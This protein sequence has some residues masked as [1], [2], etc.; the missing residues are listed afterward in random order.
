MDQR[1]CH[2]ARIHL[3]NHAGFHGLSNKRAGDIMQLGETLVA[4]EESFVRCEVHDT[5]GA[6]GV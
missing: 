2:S 3:A 4:C 6:F 5:W 1:S